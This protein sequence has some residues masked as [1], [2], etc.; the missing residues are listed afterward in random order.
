VRHVDKLPGT[1]EQKERMKGVLRTLSG[2]WTVRQATV[3]LGIGESRFHEIRD[4]VLEAAMGPLAPSRMGRPPQVE[5]EEDRRIRELEAEVRELKLELHAALVRTEVALAMP[6]VLK[7]GAS[8]KR[9][10]TPKRKRSSPSSRVRRSA[11]EASSA[12]G[13]E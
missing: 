5:T 8:E 2:E 9:G 3:R 4:E 1:R 6:R 12:T 11:G 13:S 10:S 7:E